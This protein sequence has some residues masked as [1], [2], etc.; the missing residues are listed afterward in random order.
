MVAVERDGIKYLSLPALIELKLAS[1]MTSSERI[2]DLA[3]VQ[4]LI[5]ICKLPRDFKAQLNPFVHEK[6]DALWDAAMGHARR[7]MMILHGASP[8]AAAALEA[9]LADGVTV[10]PDGRNGDRIRLTTTDPDVAARYG[11]HDE[12]EFFDEP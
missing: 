7:F 8:D 3:D 2:K 9:M 4:E 11:M 5:K 6:F 10:D 1:G 12:S